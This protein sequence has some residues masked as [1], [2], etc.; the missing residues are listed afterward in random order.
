MVTDSVEQ[1]HSTQPDNMFGSEATR[2]AFRASRKLSMH[3]SNNCSVLDAIR[4]DAVMTAYIDVLRSTAHHGTESDCD[5]NKEPSCS[6][7]IF[8][9]D[10]QRNWRKTFSTRQ[11][12]G[13]E[14]H[15]R[16]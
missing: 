13:P 1:Q 12:M 8:E 5:G 9:G 15:P 4:V 11:R 3:S 6:Y 2:Q 14:A 16:K 7:S 10:T